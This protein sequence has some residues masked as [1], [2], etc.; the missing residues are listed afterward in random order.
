ATTSILCASRL[1]D[2]TVVMETADAAAV[3][4]WSN[5]T[6]TMELRGVHDLHGNVA[7]VIT[8]G[9]RRRAL[10]D[11]SVSRTFVV[12]TLPEH[13]EDTATLAQWGTQTDSERRAAVA[14]AYARVLPSDAAVASSYVE[15]EDDEGVDG[16]GADSSMLGVGLGVTA[17]VV[18]VVAAAF[19]IIRRRRREQGKRRST[20]SDAV[21]VSTEMHAKVESDNPMHAAA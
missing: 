7:E 11:G 20:T 21:G 4:L 9:G 15:S 1:Y 19:L 3:A 18:A 8:A 16:G 17:S 2:L 13:G 5:T 14:V 6:V 10:A 12:P